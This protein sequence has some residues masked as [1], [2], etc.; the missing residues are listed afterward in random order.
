MRQ[1][2][3]IDISYYFCG[4]QAED[5]TRKFLQ[6]TIE[7]YYSPQNNKSDAVS[8]MWNFLMA[9]VK[10][11]ELKFNKSLILSYSTKEEFKY[12]VTY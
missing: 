1:F 2:V 8:L 11:E 7:N 5:E 3:F 10:K 12:L 4:S 9:Q 6:T